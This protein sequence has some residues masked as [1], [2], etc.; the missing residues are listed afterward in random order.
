LARLIPLKFCSLF[1]LYTSPLEAYFLDRFRWA[2]CQLDILEKCSSY[3][4]LQKALNSL[5]KTLDETYARILASLP[6]EHKEEAIQLLQFLTYSERPLTIEEAV[7][8][9]AVDLNNDCQFDTRYRL[10]RP[11]EI[12][13]FG[14]SLISLVTREDGAKT[15]LELQLAHFSVKEYLISRELAEPFQ[16]KFS[17]PNARGQITRICLAYLS[18]LMNEDSTDDIGSTDNIRDKFPLAQ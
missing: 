14:S 9:I 3:R 4:G 17:E 16:Y 12:S 5:P 8:A 18:S 7:D 2:A 13:R 10:P 15:F 6:E 1:L 11:S